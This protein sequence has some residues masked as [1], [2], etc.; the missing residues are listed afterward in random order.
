MMAVAATKKKARGARATKPKALRPVPA[1]TAPPAD[2]KTPEQTATEWLLQTDMHDP[3]SVAALR[4]K[5]PGGLEHATDQDLAR[6]Q[7]I[8]LH[9]A[10]VLLFDKPEYWQALRDA[11]KLLW[12]MPSKPREAMHAA[13][14]LVARELDRRHGRL[15]PHIKDRTPEQIRVAW[16]IRGL[17]EYDEAFQRLDAQSVQASLR[18]DRVASTVTAELALE[19]GAWGFTQGEDEDLAAA[20]KRYAERLK[21]YAGRACQADGSYK[22]RK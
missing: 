10:G 1:P 8:A 22:S 21:I 20:Q 2:P 16:L 15:P 19:V 6:A 9:P 4:A 5:F 14:A 3:S 18:D 7:W 12:E 17:S 13:L 11:W